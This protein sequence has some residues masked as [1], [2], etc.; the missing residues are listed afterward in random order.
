[1][2][3]WKVKGKLWDL[4]IINILF[5][6]F[7]S[8]SFLFNIS[9]KHITLIVKGNMELFTQSVFLPKCINMTSFTAALLG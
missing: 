5:I 3:L 7:P 4:I 1:M 2:L 8:F 6:L 9:V